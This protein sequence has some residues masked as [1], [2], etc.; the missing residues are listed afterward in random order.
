MYNEKKDIFQL[1]N[2]LKGTSGQEIIAI[3]FMGC[4]FLPIRKVKPDLND[5]VENGFL[6]LARV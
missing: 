5:V 4:K 1:N 2:F 6:V 3:H